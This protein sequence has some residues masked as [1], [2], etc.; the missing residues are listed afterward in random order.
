MRRSR[1]AR[2]AVRAATVARVAARPALTLAAAVAL[3]LV[4]THCY[5]VSPYAD[6]TSG[7][8]PDGG[9]GGSDARGVQFCKRLAPTPTFCRDFD[10][11]EP[12]G[13][14]FTFVGASPGGTLDVDPAVSV[15][16]TSSLHCA[17][18]ATAG[19]GPLEYVAEDVVVTRS[20]HVELDALADVLG[21]GTD[22]VTLLS[23]VSRDGAGVQRSL[24]YYTTQ[25][26]AELEEESTPPFMNWPKALPA[27]PTVGKWSHYALDLALA[28]DAPARITL[29][30]DGKK[31]L[32]DA[33]LGQPW[34]AGKYR[35]AFGLSWS[36]ASR[37]AW[38][39]H[40]DDLVIDAR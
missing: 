15:S 35:V 39:F 36:N 27:P 30:I 38:S 2:A 10:E 22:E 16:S 5:F 25:A 17:V 37:A 18:P 6:L 8:A 24:L 11:G 13:T 9:A 40:D 28:G 34:R 20:L 31:V 29:A 14:G 32:D 1:S 26:G 19:G 7:S 23:V 33:P 4:G 21:N 3:A 12:V